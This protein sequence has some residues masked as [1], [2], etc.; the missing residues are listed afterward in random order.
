MQSTEKITTA[1]TFG[2]RLAQARTARCLKKAEMARFLG[3]SAQNYQRY[4]D[5][6]IPDA[7]MLLRIAGKCN[8][9]IG[10][11]MGDP[12]VDANPLPW[13]DANAAAKTT[14]ASGSPTTTCRFPEKCDLVNRLDAQDA[15]LAHMEAQ[16]ETLVGL[17]GGR[18]QASLDES[19][20]KAG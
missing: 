7:V 20:D 6:R 11:L 3:I 14:A 13:T 19:K 16:L 12:N 9:N 15:R 17:L 8:V 10:W 5:G 2:N 1:D 18:L 4:E